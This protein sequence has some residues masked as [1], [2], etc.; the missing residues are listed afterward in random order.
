MSRPPAARI[1]I[2]A[3]LERAGIDFEAA[4]GAEL[5]VRCPFHADTQASCSI[6]TESQL[7]KCH[8]ASCGKAGDVITF[9][10]GILNQPRAAVWEYFAQTYDLKQVK[11]IEP[12]VVEA[13]HNDIWT[14]EHL[15]KELYLRGVTDHDIRRH[16]LG[17]A[18]GRVT[19][20]IKNASGSFVNIRKYLPG[21]PG[22]DKFKNTYGRS[23]IRLF[24]I[25]QL[26]HNVIVLCGGEIKAIVAARVLNPHDVGAISAT[27]G[28]GN[29]HHSLTPSFKDK[30]VYIMMDVDQGGREAAQRYA[31]ILFKIAAWVGI[32]ELPLDPDRYPHG[33]VNDF[34]ATEEGDLWQ[35]IQRTEQWVP[36]TR[37][38]GLP[39]EEPKP[40]LFSGAYQS[41]VVG[42]RVQFTACVTAAAET[43]FIVP[44]RILV[45]CQKNQEV[46]AVCAVFPKDDKVFNVSPESPAILSMIGVNKAALDVAMRNAVGIPTK[47]HSVELE[48][49]EHYDVEDVRVSPSM[50]ITNRDDARAM[51]PAVIVSCPAELNESYSFSGRLYPHPQSQ[52]ATMLVS[53]SEPTADA[54]SQYV[55]KD[56]HKLRLF[57]PMEWTVEAINE[58]FDEIYKDLEANVTRIYLRRD[59][60]LFVDL[61]YHSP[62]LLEVDGK[63]VKGWAEILI[64][65]DAGHGKT[66][67]AMNMMR[68][69]GLGEKVE[70]KNASVAGLIGGLQQ[71]G[72]EWFVSWGTI[73][74]RDKQIVILEE[75][76]GASR[77]VIARMTDTRSSGIAEISKIRRRR[78]HARTRIIALSNPR[79][80]RI[81]ETHN[82]GVEAVQELIGAPEDVRRFDAAL[83]VSARDVDARELN[84]LI[85]KPPTVAHEYTDVLC[86]ELILWG[87]TRHQD[88]IIFEKEALDALS[89]E[90]VKLAEKYTDTIPLVDRG[91][92]RY[93]LARLAASVAVRTF[94]SKDDDMVVVVRRCHVEFVS[95]TLDRVYSA[96]SFGYAAYSEASRVKGSMIDHDAV[97]A[98]LKGMAFPAE[99]KQNLL[100]TDLIEMTDVVDWTGYERVQA[101]EFVSLLV[102]KRALLRDG[103][104]G[105]RKTPEFIAWLKSID[106]GVSAKPPEFMK[107]V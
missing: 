26:S 75:L 8:S 57:R 14:Q 29:W 96:P 19:I 76:K 95:Q 107:N 94:S 33:D 23:Q 5:K 100:Y 90:S 82:F 84:T 65:G 59:I 11:I 61:A 56:L 97:L 99:I 86:R 70:C 91:S 35:V 22:A 43:P 48:A 52:L 60:H 81:M 6:N 93:R 41:E 68:H 17:H 104:N 105:Y 53:A 24:P 88:Q 4:G 54:L 66:E 98:F 85:R 25:D 30:R 10:A 67:V 38:A 73:P 83:I 55:P 46:C 42:K 62:L 20:P 92:T 78:T 71:L 45:N 3:E 63:A 16:R 74:T 28:E 49:A 80:D 18:K 87:W 13:A 106:L 32:V 103:R 40:V 31:S 39:D 2:Q 47:C 102:R 34:V 21:A 72:N 69:Y 9:F 50:D 77:E 36:P 44:K 51:Q 89:T 37:V 12:E 27:G 58:R 79:S 1:S 7:F 101:Q 64:M 15:L